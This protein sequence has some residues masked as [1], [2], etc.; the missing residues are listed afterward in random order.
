MCFALASRFWKCFPFVMDR[1]ARTEQNSLKSR[2]QRL[3]Q[4]LTVTSA[5]TKAYRFTT[6]CQNGALAML[7]LIKSKKKQQDGT[8]TGHR[9]IGKRSKSLISRP[10]EVLTSANLKQDQPELRQNQEPQ[11]QQQQQQHQQQQDLQSQQSQQSQLVVS[12]SGG[13]VLLQSGGGLSFGF[14]A[15]ELPTSRPSSAM[16]PQERPSSRSSNSSRR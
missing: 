14:T 16:P 2:P 3:L 13:T 12:S 1:A 5:E 10:I 4:L 8:R 9:L 6:V 11:Q 7:S 15:M